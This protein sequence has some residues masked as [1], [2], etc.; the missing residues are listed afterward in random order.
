MSNAIIETPLGKA[1]WDTPLRIDLNADAK[2]RLEQLERS[3][4][5]AEVV[6]MSDGS[7][8]GSYLASQCRLLLG[9]ARLHLEKKR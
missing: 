9:I 5:E 8:M 3:L 2:V 6:L 4:G 1:V 7:T